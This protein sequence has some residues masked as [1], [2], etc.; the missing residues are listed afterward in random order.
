MTAKSHTDQRWTSA[1]RK[2]FRLTG[3]WML[4]TNGIGR[5]GSCESEGRKDIDSVEEIKL[6][7]LW[8]TVQSSK[9]TRS[10]PSELRPH[11]G[12][13]SA[14]AIKKKRLN[15]C[16]EYG[17]SAGTLSFSIRNVTM[18]SISKPILHI[19]QA[20][21]PLC[22]TNMTGKEAKQLLTT[23]SAF[24]AGFLKK[25]TLIAECQSP[26]HWGTDD[27]DCDKDTRAKFSRQT[28]R[29]KKAT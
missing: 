27:S 10:M 25:V 28:D 29:I 3:I 6:V 8:W 19:L 7:N 26:A 15:L 1:I 9:G 4:M 5:S 12:W 22:R 16:L 20:L 13:T 17:G 21:S 18:M 14:R 2:T 23:L 24:L 11:S